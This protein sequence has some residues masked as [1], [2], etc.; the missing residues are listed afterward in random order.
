MTIE[1]TIEEAVARAVERN[2]AGIREDVAAIRSALPPRML[3]IAQA[4]EALGCCKS[5]VRRMVK[6]GAVKY[7]VV[8]LGRNGIRIDASSLQ[9]ADAS[10][11]GQRRAAGGRR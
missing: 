11:V 2:M 4:A 5:T 1:E 3:T 6:A 7:K 9:G 10:D 8:G